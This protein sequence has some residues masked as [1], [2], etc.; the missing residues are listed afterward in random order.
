MTKHFHVSSLF[1]WPQPTFIANG[2]L[3]S[4]NIDDQ[5]DDV[6]RRL[7]ALMDPKIMNHEIDITRNPY[8]ITE[9]EAQGRIVIGP[10]KCR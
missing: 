2:I 5:V 4:D 7:S 1:F 9:L 10:E 8:D 3:Q 6:H